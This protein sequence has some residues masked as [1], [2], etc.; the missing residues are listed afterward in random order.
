MTFRLRHLILAI[1]LSLFALLVPIVA[2]AAP[3]TVCGPGTGAGQCSN[4]RGV[5]VDP[6]TNRLY[7]ADF[8]NNRIDV[9][10]AGAGEVQFQF[11]YGWG[12]DT[13]A[14]T[15]ETC[16]ATSTCQAGISGF[17]AGEFNAARR[18]AVDDDP[19]SPAHHDVYVLDGEENG[20][21]RVQKFGPAGNILD[22]VAGLK[23]QTAPLA[24][25]PGGEVYVGDTIGGTVEPRIKKF[26]SDLELLG[27]CRPSFDG[28]L[29][30]ALAVD[31][32]GSIYAKFNSSTNL[33]K[34]NWSE[35]A[36][37]ESGSPFPLPF[38]VDTEALAVDSAGGVVAKQASSAGRLIAKINASGAVTRRYGYGELSSGT[39]GT[40]VAPLET[41][42][43]DVFVSES[44]GVKY[45]TEPPPGPVIAPPSVS[46]VGNVRAT[47]EANVNPEGKVSEY[48]TK[49][50]DDAA[51]KAEGFAS[52]KTKTTSLKALPGSPDVELHLASAQAGCAVASKA[53]VEAEECLAPETL[54]HYRVEASNEDG[55]G[56]SPAEG[57][58][59]TAPPLQITETYASEVGTDVARISAAVNPLGVPT[60]G[61]FQYVTEAQFQASGFAGAMEAPDVEGGAAPLDF[62]SSEVP[63]TRS[64]FL[65]LRPGTAY[66][67]RVLATDPLIEAPREGPSLSF[68][69]LAPEAGEECPAN[70]PYRTGPAAMLPDC[71]AYELV[72]P[73]DKAGG[74]IVTT[75]EVLFAPN[76]LIQSSLSGEGLVYGSS[77]TFGDASSSSITSQYRA[78]RG[79]G[80]SG[81]S[82]HYILGPRGRLNEGVPT[83]AFYSELRYLSPDLCGAWIRTQAEPLLAPAAIPGR[84]N[85]YRRDDSSCGA[86][87]WEALTTAPGIHGLFFP[88]ALEFQGSSADGSRAI[89]VA[90]DK[91]TGTAAPDLGGE[92]PA[93]YYQEEGEGP[94]VYVCYGTDGIP[95][96]AGCAAGTMGGLPRYR[97]SELTGAISAD[98]ERVFFSSSANLKIPELG[99]LYI[100]ERP[101]KSQSNVNGEGKCTQSARA[102]TYQVSTSAAQFWAAADDGSKALYSQGSAL[103]LYDVDAKTRSQIASG[104]QGVMGQSEDLSRVY[105]ASTEVLTTGPNAEGHSPTTG[106]TNLYLYEAGEPAGFG[107]IAALAGASDPAPGTN[108]IQSSPALHAARV[109]PDGLHAA[110][111]STA[112]LTG[113]DNADARSGKADA[114]IFLYDAAA[115][116]GQERLVCVSCN[117]SGGRPLGRS[118]D[119]DVK[120]AAVWGPEPFW[121]AAWLQTQKT[122]LYPGRVMSEDGTRLYFEAADSLVPRDTNGATD[123]Y[124]WEALG[125]GS[126]SAASSRYSARNGGCVTLISSGQ[127]QGDVLYL[128]TDAGGRNVFFTTAQSLVSQDYGLVDVY[129][130]RVDGGLPAP[131]TPT[132]GCEG[133]ACQG[134]YVPPED[135]TPAS[136]SFQGAGNIREEARKTAA[137]KCPPGKRKVKH[138]GKA[139]CG[140]QGLR[141]AAHRKHGRPSHRSRHANRGGNAR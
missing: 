88:P 113:Y 61:Y 46:G 76:A 104:V 73:L 20:I 136:S 42:L 6:E 67:F 97:S 53:A 37:A 93:L 36:C 134:P 137:R 79:P 101:G 38:P 119:R 48:E 65:S 49:W 43:G 85:L 103:Y 129:D 71:R 140:K 77:R 33:F 45:L 135:R 21:V 1:L 51:F 62:G 12:V 32:S 132:P 80:T 98:G 105:F 116:G 27:E 115:N 86:Q 78:S 64:V 50:V 126:C 99:T 59:T 141:K 121:A 66:R 124:Q 7:V 31:T 8:G 109:S 111:E 68:S 34:F 60:T 106:Q 44:N 122:S 128:D 18:I 90:D 102:C 138:R 117:P 41:S 125:S 35:P 30:G 118:L 83:A 11:A 16:T 14:A 91:L 87:G 89:Y 74:D 100:R 82:S 107:F 13:G 47:I 4:P 133:E 123:L 130:A 22:Q 139:R 56:N 70:D 54:Y 69:T 72:S 24:T 108:P 39:S 29:S 96:A 110:F 114:E 26:D 40:G 94:P 3:L 57:T 28:R 17:G 15:F 2:H 120:P 75:K 112:S 5:A 10:T 55:D 52:P 19:V 92:R 9:F 58:F 25:G 84:P 131:P 23:D 81:W 63:T 127:A 95:I